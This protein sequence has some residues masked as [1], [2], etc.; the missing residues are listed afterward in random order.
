MRYRYCKNILSSER[1]FILLTAILGCVILLALTL[2]INN[3]STSDLRVSS[4]TVGHKK[5]MTS[6]ETGLHEMM[7]NFNPQNLTASAVTNV[8]VDSTNDPG[9]VYSITAPTEPVFGPTFLPMEGYSIGG[10]QQWGQR[11]YNV[12]VTGRNTAYKT[13][14]AIGAGV[15][16]GPV[17]S[18]TQLR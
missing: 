10:G 15:G 18:T 17:E 12:D 14:V 13:S 9:S 8:Q 2:L 5:A 11:V 4:Q 7:R 6:A 3:L 16:Y 1:G